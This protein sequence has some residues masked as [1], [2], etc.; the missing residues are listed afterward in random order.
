MCRAP[1]DAVKRSTTSPSRTLPAS[2]S[3]S[4]QT[5]SPPVHTDAPLH[6]LPERSN[7]LSTTRGLDAGR[8]DREEGPDSPGRVCAEALHAVVHHE[9]VPL[10]LGHL[11]GVHL[12]VPV[13]E[14]APR[15]VVCGCVGYLPAGGVEQASCESL[16]EFR[17]YYFAVVRSW[18][19]WSEVTAKD[20]QAVSRDERERER[21]GDGRTAKQT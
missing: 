12:H 3:D 19:G 5:P 13:R 14:V 4:P 16:V 2:N 21:L 10:A 17:R 8:S 7:L 15:P 11:H 20:Y 1:P 6:P 18:G 9:E